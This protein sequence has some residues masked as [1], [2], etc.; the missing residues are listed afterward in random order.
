MEEK[1]RNKDERKKRVEEG[2]EVKEKNLLNRVI[3][4]KQAC[5]FLPCTSHMVIVL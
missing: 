5:K 1:K 3:C 2:G 4:C